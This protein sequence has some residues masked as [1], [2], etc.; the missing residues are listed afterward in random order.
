VQQHHLTK[1]ITLL[2]IKKTDK[3]KSIIITDH[4][5]YSKTTKPSE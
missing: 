3:G 4:C 1:D 5:W 2:T